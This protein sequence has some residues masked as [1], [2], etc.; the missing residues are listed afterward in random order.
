MTG[1]PWL[2]GTGL[3]GQWVARA[4]AAP[5]STPPHRSSHGQVTRTHL[6]MVC[7]NNKGGEQKKNVQ[8]HGFP[9]PLCMASSSH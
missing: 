2:S 5:P 1:L 7:S 3:P 4:E 6:S 9:E 8:N